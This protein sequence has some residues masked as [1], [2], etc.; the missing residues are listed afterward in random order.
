MDEPPDDDRL[1]GLAFLLDQVLAGLRAPILD[2][3]GPHSVAY[4]RPRYARM[5][6]VNRPKPG[7][8]SWFGPQTRSSA[9][10]Q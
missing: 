4:R 6:D 5:L 1:R 3:C 2:C 8:T 9:Q 10:P 7:G